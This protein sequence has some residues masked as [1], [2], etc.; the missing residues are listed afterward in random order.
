M[1]SVSCLQSR[2]DHKLLPRSLPSESST[3]EIDVSCDFA[4]QRVG[5]HDI[6]RTMYDV[7]V[8]IA[9]EVADRRSR[10]EIK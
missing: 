7:A 8:H 9:S 2:L 5:N 3:G 1:V 10:D 4:V 6:F